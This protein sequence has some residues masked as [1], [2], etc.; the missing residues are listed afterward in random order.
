MD[1]DLEDKVVLDFPEEEIKYEDKNTIADTYEQEI[2]CFEHKTA[3]K[4]YLLP[5]SPLKLEFLDSKREIFKIS[6]VFARQ[7][8]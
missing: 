4:G 5:E 1:Y 8:L 3:E 7:K 2:D 6:R